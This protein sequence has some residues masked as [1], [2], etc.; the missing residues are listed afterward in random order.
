MAVNRTATELPYLSR[1]GIGV[2]QVRGWR[3]SKRRGGAKQEMR[4]DDNALN[5]IRHLDGALFPPT[6][7][8]HGCS[9]SE[10]FQ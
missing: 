1:L 2:S 9:C 4:T 7:N 10:Y 8:V 3:V 6:L 5:A